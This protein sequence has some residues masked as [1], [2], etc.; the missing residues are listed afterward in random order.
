ML[1]DTTRLGHDDR[2]PDIEERYAVAATTSDLTVYPNRR[3]SVDVVIA[4]G[5]S[6][7]RLGTALIHLEGEWHRASKPRPPTDAEVARRASELPDKKGRPD[8]RRARVELFMLHQRAM[9]ERAKT[10]NGRS[11]V[12]GM[13]TDWAKERGV[14]PDL[15]GIALYH[16][17]EPNCGVCTGQGKLRHES[18]PVLGANCWHCHGAARWPTPSGAQPI[19]DHILECIGQAKAGTARRLR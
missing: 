12:V 19:R 17:L 16:W 15:I 4:A 10:L 2:P 18:A 11:A 9:R 3:G 1:A 5:M 13:L 6:G 7:A 8:T 14:D